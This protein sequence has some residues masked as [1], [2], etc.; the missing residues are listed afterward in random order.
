MYEDAFN[1]DDDCPIVDFQKASLVL[2]FD[3]SN[4]LFRS[5][6][7]RE[8]AYLTTTGGRPS[9]HV[10]NF[11]KMLLGYWN[12]YAEFGETA[13]VFGLDHVGGKE[14]RQKI[15]PDYK[16]NRVEREDLCLETLGIPQDQAFAEILECID[17]LPHNKLEAVGF[18]FDDLASAIIKQYPQK[19]FV[20]ISSDEDMWA[21][22]GSNKN[23]T[24]VNRS[25]IVTNEQLEDKYGLSN[26]GHVLNYKCLFGDTSDNIPN[27]LPN[28]KRKP[29]IETVIKPTATNAT[30]VL[31]MVNLLENGPSPK[32]QTLLADATEKVQFIKRLTTNFKVVSFLEIINITAQIHTFTSGDKQELLRLI[33][34]EYQ[35]NSLVNSVPWF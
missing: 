34:D 28:I 1:D 25:G 12:R 23:L 9:G 14:T 6:G 3:T 7:N 4:L 5:A 19:H 15:F 11:Y 32:M 24:V 31:A 18:E 16:A 13:L 29:I 27:L 8:L 33:L 2:L 26:F 20:L 10:F 30:G 21:L 17:C 35:C 22:L